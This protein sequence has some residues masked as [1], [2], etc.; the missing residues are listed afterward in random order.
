M[1][2]NLPSDP[3][4]E[5]IP[6]GIAEGQS[7]SDQ[8]ERELKKAA[9]RARILSRT[10][11]FCYPLACT[12][13]AAWSSLVG[14][15]V[16]PAFLWGG[17]CPR[18]LFLSALSA[19]AGLSFTYI[20]FSRRGELFLLFIQAIIV[21]IFLPP[22]GAFLPLNLL[23]LGMVI[24]RIT[25]RLPLWEIIYSCAPM[26]ILFAAGLAAANLHPGRANSH[27]GLDAV[28]S[29]AAGMLA[30]TV[31]FMYRCSL[32]RRVEDREALRRAHGVASGLFDANL[33]LQD[34]LDQAMAEATRQ[35]RT[36]LARELHDT[37]AYT[38]TT[39]GAGIETGAALVTRDPEAALKELTFARRLTSDGLREVRGIVRNLRDKADKGFR[40]PERW[41]AL[42]E[43]FHETVGVM[44]TLE[45]PPGFPPVVEELDEVIYRLIQEGVTNA[46]RHGQ[47][48][49]VWVRV[50]IERGHMC[51][52]ISDN[53]VGAKELGAGF[54]LL[55]LQERVHALGG[56]LSWRTSPGAGFDL[57]AEI[58]LKERRPG[59]HDTGAAG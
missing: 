46:Y 17:V 56:R 28:A 39:I 29:I 15:V 57:A 55:G 20:R 11:R 7:V 6:A 3:V 32:N 51:V 49:V 22:A 58:P 2:E 1:E 44:V 38:L 4:Q 18:P 40:G 37:V 42:A 5:D 19:W 25:V 16:Q 36:A 43:V 27:L 54:G 14:F 10:E 9:G 59:S 31:G 21:M 30:G 52:L 41:S 48:G 8:D 26:P 13:W 33:R 35:Q 45:I 23:A 47:A 53:G 50:W 34:R 24:F 12:V